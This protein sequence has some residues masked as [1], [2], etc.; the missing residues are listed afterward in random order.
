MQF[1]NQSI[2]RM[3]ATALMDFFGR[4]SIEKF[5]TISVSGDDVFVQRKVIP[6]PIQWATREKWVEIVRSSAGRKAMDPAVRDMNPVEMQWIL[7]RIS[8]NL[9]GLTFDASRRLQKTQQI[10][11]YINTSGDSIGTT[12]TGAPWTLD[13][14]VATIARHLD[15][16]LQIM[17][18]IL[19]YFAPTMSLNLNLFDNRVSESIPITLTSVSMDNPTDLPEFEERVFTNI[20]SLQVKLNYYMMKRIQ[21]YIKQVTANLQNGNEVL[22]IDKTWIEAQQRVQT[23]FTYYIDNASRPNPFININS[24]TT[25]PNYTDA[26]KIVDFL[27]LVEMQYVNNAI[28]GLGFPVVNAF[29]DTGVN[30]NLIYLSTDASSAYD[31]NFFIYYRINDDNTIYKYEEPIEVV[32]GMTDLY[33]WADFSTQTTVSQLD[34][35]HYVVS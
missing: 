5:Q 8:C 27:N 32:D 14:E 31:Q 17:E 21:G 24:G 29:R 23:K 9:T 10:T 30:P 11:D 20:Y 4:I 16:N 26:S 13:F 35:L 18:Q 19:P 25:L 1:F 12:Y 28:S 6:V 7:P 15:D 2:T 33:C 3:V 34:V 22:R